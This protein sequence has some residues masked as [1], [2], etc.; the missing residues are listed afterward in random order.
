MAKTQLSGEIGFAKLPKEQYQR[1]YFYNKDVE[2]TVVPSSSVLYPNASN[3]CVMMFLNQNWKPGINNF[4]DWRLIPCNETFYTYILVCQVSGIA[5]T[6]TKHVVLY[7]D[8]LQFRWP[9]LYDS[10]DKWE[11]LS[12]FTLSTKNQDSLKYLNPSTFHDIRSSV[13][14]IRET[15]SVQGGVQTCLNVMQIKATYSTDN[16]LSVNLLK[17]RF[18]LNKIHC[19][20]NTTFNINNQCVQLFLKHGTLATHATNIRD[21]ET[22]LIVKGMFAVANHHQICSI[23][24]TYQGKY[25]LYTNRQHH[26]CNFSK[27]LIVEVT[28]PIP[29]SQSCNA[30]HVL[31]PNG[32]CR[33]QL[34]FENMTEEGFNPYQTYAREWIH[35]INTF[36]PVFRCLNLTIP[37]YRVCDNVLDCDTGEDEQYCIEELHTVNYPILPS[38]PKVTYSTVPLNVDNVFCCASGTCIPQSWVNDLVPNCPVYRI[39]RTMFE[40]EPILMDITSTGYVGDVCDNTHNLPC[41]PGHPQCFHLSALC[42][43]DLDLYGHLKNCRN[44]AHLAGCGSHSCADMFKCPYS[45]CLPLRKVCDGHNDCPYGEDEEF[46]SENGIECPGSFHCL[47]NVCVGQS[48]VCDGK[49]DCPVLG[50]DEYFCEG[51]ICPKDCT[52]LWN[53]VLCINSNVQTVKAAQVKY[54]NI[55]QNGEIIPQIDNG[56]KM[57]ILNVSHNSLQFLDQSSFSGVPY[58]ALIDL[59][60][61]NITT[62]KTYSFYLLTNLRSI[63]LKHN[64]VTVLA[65]NSFFSLPRL[66][67]L[68]IPHNKLRDLGANTFIAT[69]NLQLNFPLDSVITFDLQLLSFMNNNT[70]LTFNQDGL[71]KLTGHVPEHIGFTYETD[72]PYIYCHTAIK[73]VAKCRINNDHCYVPSLCLTKSG[74][75]VSVTGC[76]C[77]IITLLI[78]IIALIFRS[79]SKKSLIETPQ[80]GINIMGVLISVSSILVVIQGLVFDPDV[81]H[82]V[83]GLRHSWCL[84]VSALQFFATVAMY[85]FLA[86]YQYGLHVIFTKTRMYVILREKRMAAY[87]FI[88]VLALLMICILLYFIP[89]YVF[90]IY[91]DLSELC[92]IY[93]PHTGANVLHKMLTTIHLVVQASCSIGVIYSVITIKMIVST[94]QSQLQKFQTGITHKQNV[95]RNLV[96]KAFLLNQGLPQMWGLMLAMLG[97]WVMSGG[98]MPYNIGWYFVTLVFPLWSL[99]NPLFYFSVIFFFRGKK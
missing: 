22:P 95:R 27:H 24:I 86:L 5:R 39:N 23:G 43:Y 60:S 71:K 79:K 29:L 34:I 91:P 35:V 82:A 21:A 87:A 54:L 58:V 14:K 70:K 93:L 16:F 19:G 11:Q 3:D 56:H 77:S 40:D 2:Q 33:S 84:G 97:I 38:A 64:P 52:C 99:W 48:E 49:P 13:F 80:R 9:I 66:K 12:L 44:G 47:I 89:I 68:N 6:K 8:L 41:H 88:V 7:V 46:C 42:I 96:G 73:G 25:H 85:P 20:F 51:S 76:V 62:I 65:K 75:H 81:V 45:Y 50:D 72:Q 63:Q 17:G 1:L 28:D 55:K 30:N 10:C 74:P 61:N 37:Y 69:P 78:H 31:L 83:G 26:W 4:F 92:S 18:K 98:F 32:E 57:I 94:N 53:V 36:N 67:S 59:S 90:D 15:S